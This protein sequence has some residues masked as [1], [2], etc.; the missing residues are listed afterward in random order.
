MSFQLDC[1]AINPKLKPRITINTNLFN[2]INLF[3]KTIVFQSCV[4]DQHEVWL[5]ATD[6]I[7]DGVY[8]GV[9]QVQDDRGELLRM[10]SMDQTRDRTELKDAPDEMF[11][12]IREELQNGQAGDE[13][14]GDNPDDLLGHDNQAQRIGILKE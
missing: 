3:I 13:S 7:L 8:V 9:L 1:R 2:L 11:D 5:D 10:A 6:E 12:V 14:H 4:Y